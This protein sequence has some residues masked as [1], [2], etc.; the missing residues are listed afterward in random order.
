MKISNLKLKNKLILAPM[1]DVTDIAYRLLCKKYGA[2]LVF[3]EMINVEG[4]ARGNKH[5]FEIIKHCEE[6]RPVGVQIVTN[7]TDN[8]EKVI[9][10]LKKFDLVDINCGCPVPKIVNNKL[11]AALLDD[12]DKVCEIVKFLKKRLDIPVTVKLRLGRKKINVL[13]NA[14][15][16]EKAGADGLIIH[17][18][19]AEARYKVKADWNWI[20][21]VKKSVKIPVI[22]N[23]DVF[24]EKSAKELLKKCDGIMIGRGAIGNPMIFREI[25]DSVKTDYG[26]RI[27]SFFEYVALCKRFKVYKFSKVKKMS[28]YFISGMK[29]ARK[30]RD[31][32]SGA[33]NYSEIKDLIESCL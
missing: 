7:K 30:L 17:A 33:K 8:L 20:E 22:G 19:T 6:E 26:E 3:T 5:S 14:K 25:L 29:G 24:D 12:I 2:G 27:R 15:K 4:L 23:G 28:M 18:R 21:K 1:A 11:G 9:P 13:E 10:Y 32:L 31:G 16:I